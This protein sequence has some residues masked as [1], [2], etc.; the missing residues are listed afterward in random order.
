MYSF[1]SFRSYCR[2]MAGEVLYTGSQA[3]PFSVAV[4]GEAVYFVPQSS[5]TPRRADSEK[6]ERVLAL[7][8][9][10]GEWSP[11]KYQAITFHASYILAVAKHRGA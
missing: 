11:G 6:T 9:E 2:T 10:S 7:L 3:K 1:E 8:S 5:G 4:E